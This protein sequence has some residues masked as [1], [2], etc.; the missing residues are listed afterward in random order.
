VTFT[1][2]WK[3][4]ATDS[5][6]NT[7]T[8]T[9]AGTSTDTSTDPI[10]ATDPVNDAVT[11]ETVTNPDGSTTTVET[12]ES[13]AVTTTNTTTDGVTGVTVT[14]A[15]GTVTSLSAQI[16]AVVA[17]QA[18]R[19]GKSVTV[20]IEVKAAQ[21]TA[22]APAIALSVPSGA[23]EVK[24]DIPVTDVGAGVV[25]VIVNADGTEEIVKTCTVTDDGV[26]LAVSGDTTV[27]I[28]DNTKTFKDVAEDHWGLEVITFTTA[29]TIF[30]GTSDTTF[31]PE[32]DMSRG[33]LAQVLYNLEN[34]PDTGDIADFVDV[35]PD[36]WYAD[37]VAWAADAGVVEGYGNG[38]FGPTDNITREQM[39]VMLWRYAGKPT[40]STDSMNAFPDADSVSAYAQ[41]AMAW[42][43]EN[44]I[45][46]GANGKLSPT[47]N[48]TRVQV[49]A[50][51]MRYCT[52][53]T[54]N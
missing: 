43:I 31:E 10:T 12:S 53:L 42:A 1:A 49:A 52:Y 11:T 5:S 22:S 3:Q 51:V 4:N 20:P 2:Q 21:S 14:N 34:A 30:N 50:V 27:K 9:G 44:G 39:V 18:A 28:V 8:N 24:V 15:A 36:A 16:P 45:I 46:N 54:Q 6:T 26:E 38:R 25:A 13:G 32:V 7:G 35:S 48:A 47:S 33:M 29:R 17:T 37:A 19:S 23:G 40:A 41:D